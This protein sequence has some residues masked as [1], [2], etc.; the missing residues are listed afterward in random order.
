M[1][2]RSFIVLSACFA[3]AALA[4]CAPVLRH[5]DGVRITGSFDTNDPSRKVDITTRSTPR[6]E[7]LAVNDPDPEVRAAAALRVRDQALLRSIVAGDTSTAVRVAALSRLKDE[8]DIADVARDNTDQRVRIEALTLV[9]L[10]AVLAGIAMRHPDSMTR[11][12]AAGSSG[13]RPC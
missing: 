11:A 1:E 5:S 3:L 9:R 6:I 12:A 10:P 2:I 8:A 7:R 4:G 13:T